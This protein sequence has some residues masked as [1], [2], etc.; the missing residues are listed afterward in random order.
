MSVKPNNLARQLRNNPFIALR[1]KVR[2]YPEKFKSLD[3]ERLVPSVLLS[4]VEVS[5]GKSKGQSLV[6]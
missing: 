5:R 6:R 4:E 1:T 2:I 3:P